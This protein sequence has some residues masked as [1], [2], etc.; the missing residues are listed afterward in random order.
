MTRS[1]IRD[2]FSSRSRVSALF[3]VIVPVPKYWLLIIQFFTGIFGRSIVTLTARRY[4]CGPLA[5]MGSFREYFASGYQTHRTP[6]IP[7]EE[8]G[9]SKS[10]KEISE[11]NSIS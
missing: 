7:K 5:R 8:K 9:L 2:V 1:R 11:H 4:R 10:Y 3:S 6:S